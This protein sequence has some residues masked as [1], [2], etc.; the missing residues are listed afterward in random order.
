VRAYVGPIR[1]GSFRVEL[2]YVSIPRY[3]AYKVLPANDLTSATL[4]AIDKTHDRRRV[5]AHTIQG[6]HGSARQQL[7]VRPRHLGQDRT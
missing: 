7:S 3:E 6:H 4:I 2:W 5:T 1:D